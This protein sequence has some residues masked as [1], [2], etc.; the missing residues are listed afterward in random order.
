MQ[1]FPNVYLYTTYGLATLIERIF[2]SARPQPRPQGQAKAV[3]PYTIEIIS[4]LERALAMAFTGDARVIVRR[5]MGHFGLRTSLLEQGLPTLTRAID[6]NNPVLD[7]FTQPKHWPTTKDREPAEASKR[8]QMATY[9]LEHW[10]VSPLVGLYGDTRCRTCSIVYLRCT[11]VLRSCNIAYLRVPC[12]LSLCRTCSIVH[13]RPYLCVPCALYRTCSIVHLRC[14]DVMRSCNIPYLHV[15][16][17][18]SLCCTCSM[19]QRSICYG[20]THLHN[21]GRYPE[22]ASCVAIVIFSLLV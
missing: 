9:G 12:A 13:L 6:W 3:S 17:A 15:P 16:C 2:Q 10:L 18:L 7:T 4:S 22:V 21:C 14:T 5:L 19:V 11:D 20:I 8:C 1:M